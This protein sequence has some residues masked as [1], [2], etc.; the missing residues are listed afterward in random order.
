MSEIVKEHQEGPRWKIVKRLVTFTEADLLRTELSEEIDLQV[1]IHLMGPQNRRVFAVKTRLDPKSLTYRML[2]EQRQA[3]EKKKKK[4]N[5]KHR[6][7]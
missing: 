5:K 4:S 1:K 6:R 2:E 3:K 7:K